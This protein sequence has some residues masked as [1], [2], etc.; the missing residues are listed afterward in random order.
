MCLLLVQNPILAAAWFGR[1]MYGRPWFRVLADALFG[2][3]VH[4]SLFLWLCLLQGLKYRTAFLSSRTP[5]L[6]LALLLAMSA[7]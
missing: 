2:V 1:G 6:C 4:G 7:V 5:R 3:R